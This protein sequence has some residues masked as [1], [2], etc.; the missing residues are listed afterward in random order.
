MKTP[1]NLIIFPEAGYKIVNGY[2]HSVTPAPKE[3]TA[4][5]AWKIQ[6]RRIFLG[7]N[8]VDRIIVNFD[9]GSQDQITD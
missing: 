7:W 6:A 9:D 1:R 4:K 8:G 3:I 2:G 5:R